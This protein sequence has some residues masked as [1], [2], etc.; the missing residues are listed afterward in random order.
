MTSSDFTI[1]LLVDKTPREV[2][3]SINNVRAWWTENLEGYSEK[4]NDEFTVRFF[5]DIH[6]T[7]QKLIEVVPDKKIVWLVTKSQLNFLNDKH[8]WTNTK[9]CFEITS[10]GDKTQL[11]FTH[12]GLVPEIECYSDCSKGWAQYIG[13]SLFKLLTEGKGKP[14]LKAK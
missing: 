2:F 9:I 14:E 4:L 11:L 7:T 6:V 3:D 5:D 10:N 1:T 8:E 13:E 12:Q